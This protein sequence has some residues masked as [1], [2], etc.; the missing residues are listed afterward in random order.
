MSGKHHLPRV[1][2]V[3]VRRRIS[4]GPRPCLVGSS[5]SSSAVGEH[6]VE[7]PVDVPVQAS[8]RCPGPNVADP[9]Q[10]LAQRSEPLHGAAPVVVRR[11]R[12]R[13]FRP[14]AVRPHAMIRDHPSRPRGST[15][16]GSPHT[17]FGQLLTGRVATSDYHLQVSGTVRSP[18]MMWILHA[19]SPGSASRSRRFGASPRGGPF[20]RGP[21][22]T[23]PLTAAKSTTSSDAGPAPRPTP[24]WS[25]SSPANTGSGCAA[26]SERPRRP[27]K[28]HERRTGTARTTT[29]R[30]HPPRFS[31]R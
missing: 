27:L 20:A 23:P 14:L 2:D 28:G 1:D 12:I 30:V 4:R 25:T 29:G 8:K 5:T 24:G 13:S 18:A 19:P 22:S 15:P 10:G 11:E 21:H 3:P 9:G 31:G 7:A 17:C 16:R 6:R 26:P